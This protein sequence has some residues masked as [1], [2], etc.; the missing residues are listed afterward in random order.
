MRFRTLIPILFAL[1]AIASSGCR[2]LRESCPLVTSRW[3]MDDPAYAKRYDAPYPDDQLKKT[4]RMARQ[5]VDARH[6]ADRNGISVGV[7]YQADPDSLGGR[8]GMFRYP[9]PNVENY[10]GFSG[11]DGATTENLMLGVD[12]GVRFQPATRIAPFAG[13]GGFAGI[14]WQSAAATGA[15]PVALAIDGTLNDDEDDSKSFDEDDYPL[16][17]A[18]YSEEVIGTKRQFLGAFYPEIGVHYWLTPN[19]R[20]TG[21]SQYWLTTLGRDDDFWFHSASVSFLW[22]GSNKRTPVSRASRARSTAARANSSRR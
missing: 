7:A 11:V 9:S 16:T 1:A 21:S 18:L 19:I 15:I 4:E 20:L 10:I 22:G 8:V 6:V 13:V 3:A 17:G 2:A 5:M 12:G 14:G